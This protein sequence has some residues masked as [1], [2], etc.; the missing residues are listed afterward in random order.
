ML[1]DGVDTD[2]YCPDEAGELNLGDGRKLT[3]NDKVIT[4]CARS[5][6]P[7]R[8]FLQFMEAVS[9]TQVADPEIH[10]V[11]IS[12]DRV[13]MG[14]SREDGKTYKEHALE[15]FSFNED[16][17][18]FLG[19]V[20]FNTLRDAFRVSSVH[21]YLTVPFVLSW[22]MVEAMSAG[23]FIL[24]SSTTPV[25]EVVED[26]KNGKLVEFFDVDAL[27][28]GIIDA[29]HNP[30]RFRAMREQARVT[31]RSRYSRQKCFCPITANCLSTSRRDA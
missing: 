1:H 19:L 5:M 22:S 30:D 27:T 28:E 18:H 4:Y 8:G 6:E 16:K 31:A 29:C 2:F 25:T 13:A 21:V 14:R 9:G 20:P 17:L 11:I 24:G 10:A 12:A 26:G 7:Y 23:C 15:T 3:A